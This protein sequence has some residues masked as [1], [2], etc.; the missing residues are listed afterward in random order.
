[1]QAHRIPN[2]SKGQTQTRVMRET[3]RSSQNKRKANH[4]G[5]TLGEVRQ[6]RPWTFPSRAGSQKALGQCPLVLTGKTGHLEVHTWLHHQWSPPQDR[7]GPGARPGRCQGRPGE[8]VEA[9]EAQGEEGG[10]QGRPVQPS[11]RKG[12]CPAMEAAAAGTVGDAGQ[13]RTSPHLLLGVGEEAPG[14]GGRSRA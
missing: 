5:S 4:K 8:K 14:G 10:P 12:H 2:R 3:L 9:A 13:G 1:M 6:N 7:R 11:R